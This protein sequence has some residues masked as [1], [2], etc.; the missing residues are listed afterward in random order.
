M[1]TLKDWGELWLNEGFANFFENSIPNN[2]NDGEIQRN[3][4]ATLDFDYALRKD[5]FATSRPLS[6]IIDTPSEIHETFDGISYD[7][8]GAILEMTANLMGAQKFRK[9]LNL[10]L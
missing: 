1:V 9:G 3:A 4:Q 7:K 10:V 2:E 6:S 8:G 5:C